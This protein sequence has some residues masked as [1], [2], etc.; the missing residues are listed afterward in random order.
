MEEAEILRQALRER[1]AIINRVAAWLRDQARHTE[2]CKAP[3]E[4]CSCGLDELRKEVGCD[5]SSTSSTKS[6]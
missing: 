6:S 5:S 2:S 3:E 4:K 1:Q